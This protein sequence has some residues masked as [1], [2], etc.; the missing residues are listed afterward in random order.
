MGSRERGDYQGLLPR[1]LSGRLASLAAS[2]CS[3]VRTSGADSFTFFL[4]RET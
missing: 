3:C 4:A 2:I 1:L